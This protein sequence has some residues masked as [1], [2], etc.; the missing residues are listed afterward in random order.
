MNSKLLFSKC[1]KFSL[2]IVNNAFGESKSNTELYTKCPCASLIA[3]SLFF[4]NN[5]SF[6]RIFNPKT[7]PWY[8][9]SKFCLLRIDFIKSCSSFIESDIP[10]II[11]PLLMLWPVYISSE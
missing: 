9:S 4:S 11:P 1:D 3:F 6:A 8:P 5:S 2:N 10:T 7:A